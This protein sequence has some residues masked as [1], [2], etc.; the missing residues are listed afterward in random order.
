MEPGL[1][2]DRKDEMALAAR[3][4]RVFVSSTFQDLTEER[5]ALHSRVLPRLR[6]ICAQ[7]GARFQEIDL[8]WGVRTEASVDQQAMNICLAEIQRCRDTSPRP[9]FI[10]LL[11]D[12]YGWRPLPAEIPADEF[13]Q[14][15]D[16]VPA[17]E[18]A[19]LGDWYERD[20]NAVPPEY[21]LK[22]RDW[23][24][25]DEGAWD[26]VE[27]ELCAILLGA[28]ERLGWPRGDPRRE[29]Y[30][31]SATEREIARGA[32][33]VADADE[34]V[35]CFFRSTESLP[36]DAP[37]A[38]FRDLDQHGHPDHTARER[39]AAL[40]RRLR[41]YLPG[42]VYDYEARWTGTRATDTHIDRLCADVEHVLSR[43]I[44]DELT[45]LEEIDPLEREVAA[46]IS[47]GTER[48]RGF[49]GRAGSL[50]RVGD[51]VTA[52]DAHPLAV[53]GASG[54]GKSALMA[55]A[56][57]LARENRPRAEVVRR[58][59]GATPESSDGRSLLS[60][61]CRE[62][63]RRYEPVESP[64]PTD[65]RE[66]VEELPKRLALAT[67]ERPLILL[68]DALDQLSPS[69][70][71]R[72]LLWLPAQ[73]PQHAR[74]IVST[75]S[76]A[77]GVDQ[78]EAGRA[79][80]HECLEALRG[81]LPES[82]LVELERMSEREGGELLGLWLRDV[83]R[84]LQAV[85]RTE[86]L[87]KFKLEGLPLYLKLAFE[88]ARRWKS[89]GTHEPLQIGIPGIIRGNLFRRLADDAN[90][91]NL[92]VSR[93]LAYL[94][95]A[96]NGLSEDEL[97]DLLSRDADVFEDFKTRAHHTPPQEELPVVVWSRL[98]FDLEPY[99]SERA[100]DG[101][102]L[103]SFY[104]RQL[105]EVVASD[106]LAGDEGRDRHRQLASYFAD[107]ELETA[108]EEGT[109]ANLRKLSE[110]PYQQT[111]GELW[112]ELHDTLTDFT[113]LEHKA[114]DFGAVDST[115]AE[116][117]PTKTYT[118]VFSLQ[119]DYAL[120]LERIPGDGGAA[121]PTGGRPRIIVTGTDLGAGLKVR[122]PHCNQPSDWNDEWRGQAIECPRCGG[123]WKVN[124]FV[125]EQAARRD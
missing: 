44:R 72:R 24:Y 49:T 117:N 83:G 50:R 41:E 37:A 86:V 103:M 109:T 53:F 36:D 95:A 47:F 7:H 9:N 116:G 40:K 71:A 115:D 54:S 35:F 15:R 61:L 70:G 25:E 12:R 81:K 87:D 16:C 73:V 77:T 14:L 10:V 121:G 85:Q 22:P 119:D 1:G 110:L 51:Y 84:T 21:C 74:L 29:K 13:E 69:E 59:I 99:L 56:A 107:Q 65:Y 43:V 106:H 55:R 64:T 5:N 101:A 62:I 120:A 34:H 82:S 92:M 17:G 27:R 102:S 111:L 8:R 97:L 96:K 33:S 31:A 112:D 32:L 58:F 98:Y 26:Q 28:V 42:N 60:S 88:E 100:A 38:G 76:Q 113:F 80:A 125:V 3:T 11:G 66:L 68:L 118:G 89:Y 30:E 4:F 46:H 124:T 20:E 63:S 78:G 75:L 79:F 90:H 108:G 114:A 123:P 67:E 93:S 91:G 122:C 105:A 6:E 52:G 45:R 19:R 2:G 39:L 104:H 23:R 18:Q 94:S 48:A 57:Q